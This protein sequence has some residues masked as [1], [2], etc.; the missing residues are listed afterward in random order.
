MWIRTGRWWVGEG[1]VALLVIDLGLSRVGNSGL[2]WL[3]GWGDG[4]VRGMRRGGVGVDMEDVR[5]RLHWCW[6]WNLG[7]VGVR[8][9]ARRAG[10]WDRV[11]RN[12]WEVCNLG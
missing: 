4:W 1:R 8:E 9:R 3:G 12:R 5:V 11:C 7:V 6:D 10:V 2:A